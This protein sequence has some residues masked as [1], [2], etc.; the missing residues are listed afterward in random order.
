MA[1]NVLYVPYKSKEIRPVYLSK[2]NLNRKNQ[3]IQ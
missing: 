2:H 1:L 3:V